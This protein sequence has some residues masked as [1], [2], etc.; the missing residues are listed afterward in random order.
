MNKLFESPEKKKKKRKLSL[1]KKKICKNPVEKKEKNTGNSHQILGQF[2]KLVNKGFS[3]EEIIEKLDLKT[4]QF[5]SLLG[6]FYTGLENEIESKSPLKLFAEIVSRK[7]KLF[8]DLE[9]FKDAMEKGIPKADGT[10]GAKWRNG[11]AYVMAVKAQDAILDSVVTTGQ[12]LGLVQKAAD[13]VHLIGDT[14]VR[15]MDADTIEAE[16]IKMFDDTKK[17]LAKRGVDQSKNRNN[18]ISFPA[19]SKTT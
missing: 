6:A 3:R 18:V 1:K 17:L 19:N 9:N 4:N 11:Q 13:R 10:P 8:R 5:E 16:I 14:D 7:N 2:I 15:D 12:N